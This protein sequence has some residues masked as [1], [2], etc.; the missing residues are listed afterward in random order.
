[1]FVRKFDV[2]G[3]LIPVMWELVHHHCQHLGHRVVHTLHATIAIWVEGAGGDFPNPK[4]L[5]DGMR[6]L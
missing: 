6:K 1:M 5:V 4:K 2:R 3:L